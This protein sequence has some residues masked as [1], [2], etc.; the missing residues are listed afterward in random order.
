MSFSNPLAANLGTKI[1]EELHVDDGKPDQEDEGHQDDHQEACP[2]TD[3][4]EEEFSHPVVESEEAWQP[5]RLQTGKL[6]LL[7]QENKL[8]EAI[9]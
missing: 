1:A 5:E 2:V 9:N 7:P 4:L 8:C 3:D 6:D